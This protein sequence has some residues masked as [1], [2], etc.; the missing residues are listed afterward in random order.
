MS[1]ASA[2]TLR[3]D[4]RGAAPKPETGYLKLGTARSPS[5]S[6]IGVNSRYLT[7]DGKPWL[8]V[9]GE[10]HYVRT[11]ASEW[12]AELAKIK[13]SGVDILATYLIWDYH[14]EVEG[15]FDWS[16][17]RDLRRFI[18]TAGRHGLKVFL[19]LGPWVHA[20]VRYGGIPDWVVQ[21]MPTRGD[22]A[23]YL[24]HVRRF[25]SETERQVKGLLWKNGGPIIGVQ[26]ENEYN[27]RGVNQGAKHIATLKAMAV[28]LGFDVPLY[29]VTGWDATVYPKRDVTPVFGGYPDE[30]WGIPVDKL[31]PKETYAFRFGSRVSGDLGAQTKGGAVGD[32]DGDIE[33]TPFLGAEFGGGI[34]TMYRRRP[35]MQP[36]DIAA[37]LPVQL[38][39][40]VNLYGYYMYHGGRNAIGRTTL[41]EQTSIGGYNDLPI[42]D[43]D[44]QAPFGQYGAANPVLP[45][46]RPF[47]LFLQTWGPV[48]AP[49]TVRKPDVT[50]RDATDLTAPRFSVRTAG[51]AGFLFYN[52][53]VRQYAGPVQRGVRFAVDLPGGTVN[54]PDRAIDIPAD[55]YFI[56][57]IN[58][59]LSGDSSLAWA[60]AQP[61][62]R[63]TTPAG[64]VT[65]L[66][67]VPDVPVDLAIRAAS[68]TTRAGRVRRDG[69]LFKVEGLAAGTSAVVDVVD[70]GGHRDRILV[71]TQDQARGVS[72][73]RIGHAD[74]L[75]MTK[76][77]V[78]PQGDAL[79][80][81]SRGDP[82]F[83]FATL[84]ALD[85]VTGS[86]PVRS[87]GADGLFARY[88]ATAVPRRATVA[89]TSLRPAGK[90]PPVRIGGAANAAVEPYPES[91]STAAAWTVLVP[92]AATQGVEDTRLSIDWTGDIGRLFIG[93]ELIDDRYYDGRTWTVNLRRFGDRLAKPLTLSILPLR[94]DAPIYL[95]A[96]LKPKIAADEQVAK[97]SAV[98][99]ETDYG[100]DLRFD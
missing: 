86:R 33:H 97:L 58:L 30:P 88:T 53:H 80:L 98:R 26:I 68:V 6:E 23:I 59:A 71:L 12:D 44:F 7:L 55:R 2:D 76:A 29:T 40:G 57:P 91:F 61:L 28:N 51:D 1:P 5:G 27:L 14:E 95:D 84:P 25:W 18:E 41:Q 21:S 24:D 81:V 77:E 79:H 34:P 69:A 31:P 22:D 87:T 96:A 15:K 74:R 38:G 35:V 9:M 36:D 83:A 60:T 72:R 75:L 13:A 63:I 49:M 32:A 66:Y 19:R 94:G 65:V 50:P 70:A 4:A 52:S 67:A 73:V 37:M 100:L 92:P 48:L 64:P 56:W 42:V 3:V 10:F 62:T 17:D 43:Y 99:L 89:V 20:E 47:H 8:P 78:V 46:I 54:F 39:S 93:S 82:G 90:A 16:G 45:A 85:R 11:P